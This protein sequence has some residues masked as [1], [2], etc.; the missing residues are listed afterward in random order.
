MTDVFRTWILSLTA[1]ALFCSVAMA[2]VP[3]G[4]TAGVLRLVCGIALTLALTAPLLKVDPA[5][6]LAEAASFSQMY[7]EITEAAEEQ[8]ESQYRGII[9][10]ESAA[11]IW[12]KAERCGIVLTSVSVTAEWDAVT[13]NWLPH[14]ASVSLTAETI[15]AELS[16]AI[17]ADLGIPV[18]RQ[19]W[20]LA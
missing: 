4:R 19:E 17:A 9:E 18:E 10:E 14:T 16:A 3:K 15:P 6:Y 8:A 13:E 12:D 1:T 11:Y 7:R 2:V 20:K 5:E